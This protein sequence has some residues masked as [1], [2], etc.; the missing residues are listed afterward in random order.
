MIEDPSEAVSR[1]CSH[2]LVQLVSGGHAEF[3][4]ILT[5]FL[6]VMP[7]ARYVSLCILICNYNGVESCKINKYNK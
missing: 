4:F 6:N 1:L 5:R 3:D 2:C 7:S